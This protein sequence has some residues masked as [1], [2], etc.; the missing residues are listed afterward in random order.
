MEDM[1]AR[2]A[3]KKC[4][5]FATDTN[6]RNWL[7]VY[8]WRCINT[9]LN[10]VNDCRDLGA[11]L[12]ISALWKKGSTLT[13]RMI[14]GIAYSKLLLYSK[15]PFFKKAAVLRGKVEVAYNICERFGS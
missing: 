15:A 5:T 7:R 11:H 12:N 14:N 3:P 2:L 9:T 10:V 8:K 6:V 13:R 4:M 1:G